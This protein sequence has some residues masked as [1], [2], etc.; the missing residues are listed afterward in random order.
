MS[1]QQKYYKY[2]NKYNELVSSIEGGFFGRRKPK[3]EEGEPCKSKFF[4]TNCM[5]GLKCSNH[6]ISDGELI[7]HNPKVCVRKRNIPTS[8]QIRKLSSKKKKKEEE[9]ESSD[10]SEQYQE[11]DDDF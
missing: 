1:Y 2:L 4:G 7:I 11:P 8:S 6:Q 10:D 9:S 5:K 3:I